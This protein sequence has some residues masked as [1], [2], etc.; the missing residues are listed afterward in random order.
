MEQLKLKKGHI[1]LYLGL[2]AAVLLIMIFT[3]NLA[4]KGNSDKAF[5]QARDSLRVAIQISPIGISTHGDT[6]DGFYYDMIR[7]M[8]KKEHLALKIDGF[9]QVKMHL[10]ILKKASATL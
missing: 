2:L 8:A 7:Q 6:L 4:A 5:V 1:I 3:R 9:T 10:T